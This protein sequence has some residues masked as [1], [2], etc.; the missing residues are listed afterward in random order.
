M[1]WLALLSPD[2]HPV[3]AAILA[4]AGHVLLPVKT[5]EVP[6][7]VIVDHSAKKLHF[8]RAGFWRGQGLPVLFL[9][10]DYNRRDLARRFGMYA[11][12]GPDD[13]RAW[14]R[15][16]HPYLDLKLRASARV[17]LSRAVLAIEHPA[18]AV[19]AAAD[20]TLPF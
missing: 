5:D 10:K 8:L 20:E 1:K 18:A 16:D 4:D 13:L 15:L 2:V 12:M 17:E 7:A 3:I 14:L 11:L 19:H 6:D 9:G